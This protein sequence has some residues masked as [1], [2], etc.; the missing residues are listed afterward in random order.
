MT[1]M[2]LSEYINIA[3]VTAAEKLLLSADLPITEVATKC[4]FNDSNYFARVFKKLK[5]VTPK[6]YSMQK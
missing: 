1:G 4:G 5:G 6:K 3:R 2:G